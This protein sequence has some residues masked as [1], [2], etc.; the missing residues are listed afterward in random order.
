VR[1]KKKAQ[2]GEE[3]VVVRDEEK[4]KTFKPGY[5]TLAKFFA[6]TGPVS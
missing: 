4:G 1:E 6:V 3:P 2:G 5:I